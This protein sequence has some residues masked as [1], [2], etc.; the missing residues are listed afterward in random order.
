MVKKREIIIFAMLLLALMLNTSAYEAN[1]T[2]YNF[3]FTISSGDQTNITSANYQNKI[4]LGIISKNLNS[5]NYVNK[6]GFL[7]TSFYLD[8]EQCF[9]DYECLGGYC[10]TNACQST[11]CPTEEAAAAGGGE[12][13]GGGGGGGVAK[14]TE[15]EIKEFD[16]IISP[17]SAKF[18]IIIKKGAKKTFTI[19][20]KGTA[21]LIG[22]IKI[23]GVDKFI[24]LSD[25]SFDIG[26]GESK[27]IYAEITTDLIGIFTGSIRFNAA[28]I[29]KIVPII[30]EVETEKALF[31]VNMDIP[32]QYKRI[33]KGQDLRVQITLFNVMENKV[34]VYVTY[35]IKDLKGNLL[36]EESETFMVD[37]QKSYTKKFY[38]RKLRSGN[39][40]AV[41]EVRYANSYAVSSQMFEI[42][43]EKAIISETVR[44][45]SIIIIG[46]F[47]I[48][49][50]ALILISRF[51]IKIRKEKGKK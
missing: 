7:Y 13:G 14:P 4:I 15:E 40:V 37:R 32:M 48:T 24:S 31:D 18:K 29:T 30:I 28:G 35:L 39:Y 2:N 47:F 11:S 6:V 9:Y 19:V 12:G 34:D 10:C 3:D 42:Q 26:V 43:E 8:G 1:S 27:D 25:Y 23:I 17:S 36:L 44:E 46:C 41:I 5:T 33:K 45:L 16:F 49:G 38:T 50:L 22:T 21:N 20:N 51:K